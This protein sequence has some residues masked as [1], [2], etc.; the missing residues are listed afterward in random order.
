MIYNNVIKKLVS[1]Y[2]KQIDAGLKEAGAV[3]KD[4]A[5]QG[6]YLSKLKWNH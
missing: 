5:K 6:E 2:E 4:L 3:A 1:K